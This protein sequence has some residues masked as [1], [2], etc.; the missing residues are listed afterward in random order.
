MIDTLLNSHNIHIVVT[1]V[2]KNQKCHDNRNS[3]GTSILITVS[4]KMMKFIISASGNLCLSDSLH[5]CRSI[6]IQSN[7]RNDFVRGKKRLLRKYPKPGPCA[8]GLGG[9]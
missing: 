4:F 2:E 7:C 3:K 5:R 8:T 6:C 1:G 9:F